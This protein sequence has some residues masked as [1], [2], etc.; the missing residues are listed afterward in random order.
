MKHL[1]NAFSRRSLLLGAAALALCGLGITLGAVRRG[2]A[3]RPDQ[4]AADRWAADDTRYAQIS[5]YLAPEEALDLNRLN[6]LR[7]GLDAALTQASMEPAAQNARLWLDA[8]GAELEMS[9]STDRASTTVTALA[10]TGDHFLFHPQQLLSGSV[11]WST[12]TQHDTVVLDELA[13]W[14][15]FGSNDVV[16][17]ALQLDGKVYTVCGVAAVP[18]DAAAALTYG[19]RPRVW[20]WYDKLYPAAGAA[21]AAGSILWYEVL[22][23]DPYTGYAKKLVEDTFGTAE[24][25]CI[26]VEN[27]RRYSIGSLWSTLRLLPRSGMRTQAA[28]Y[29]WWENAAAYTQMRAALLFGAQALAMLYPAVLLCIGAV[30]AW[31][32]RP[33]LLKKLA[34]ALDRRRQRRLQAAWDAAEH[35]DPL[36]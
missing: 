17:R 1:W 28:A 11:F 35:I 33:R 25:D 20:V 4:Q 15:L 2:I 3:D 18:T 36:A 24:K 13:A 26:V 5:V 29:P 21:D 22:L 31:R 12:D 16:G 6:A 19:Q 32:R 14:Q 30:W 7:A 34:A 23:P 10:V 8:A 9:A 27:S